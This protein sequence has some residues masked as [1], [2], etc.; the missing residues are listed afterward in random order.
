MA[1]EITNNPPPSY[2]SSLSQRQSTLHIGT[3]RLCESLGVQFLY[4]V[5]LCWQ[6]RRTVGRQARPNALSFINRQG[7]GQV[8][9]SICYQA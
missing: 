2:C 4:S 7:Y 3:L 5:H 6:P 8:N 9:T 1:G